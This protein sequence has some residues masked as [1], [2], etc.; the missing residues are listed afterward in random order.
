MQENARGE[1]PTDVI[2]R[3]RPAQ[4]RAMSEMNPVARFFVN[5]FA[6]G[7]NRRRYRWLRAHL[8]ISPGARCLEI[9][10][11]NGDLA[12]RIVDGLAP[13][14]YVA[15]DLDDRQL[16]VARRHLAH[17][18]PGGLPKALELQTADMLD[19][20]FPEG[21]FD[22]VFAYTVL[23]HA[24]EE[25][26]DFAKVP[27]AL[28]EIGRVLRPGG[29]LVYEEIFLKDEIRSWLAA[30]HYELVA[31]GSRWRRESAVFRKAAA[32][33]SVRAS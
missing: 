2:S 16:A 24:S 26:R 5:T 9:G 29:S 31:V 27:G 6:G 7:R 32:S 19:L 15:T 8:Q 21:S 4:L 1:P 10:C 28:T 11:G 18:Y 30:E 14:R 17:R 3:D 33:Q 22:L 12:A 25:H 23:H 13:S 20:P